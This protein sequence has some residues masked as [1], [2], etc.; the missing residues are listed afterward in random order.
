MKCQCTVLK[1]KYFCL[2][3]MNFTFCSYKL[4]E[5]AKKKKQNRD[6]ERVN[7]YWKSE[8]TATWKN[9]RKQKSEEDN[10]REK[11]YHVHRHIRSHLYVSLSD[12]HSVLWAQR[13]A[14]F[15][16]RDGTPILLKIHTH[17]AP[18]KFASRKYGKMSTQVGTVPMQFHFGTNQRVLCKL[19]SILFNFPHTHTHSHSMPKFICFNSNFGRFFITF[20]VSHDITISQIFPW[21]HWIVGIRSA[22]L[23]GL[24]KRIDL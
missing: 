21:S 1:N 2:V 24:S 22:T 14:C 18:H 7:P 9:D 16:A 8:T 12:V 13:L 4:E 10:K 11:F 17:T 20:C 5:R 3:N 19:Y 15:D 6:T 23:A